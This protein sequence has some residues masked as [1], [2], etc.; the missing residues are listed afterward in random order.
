MFLM[1]GTP[2]PNS[3][4]LKTGTKYRF[5][6]INITGATAA[7]RVSLR[8]GGVPGQWRVVAKDAVDLPPAAAK[9]KLA[10][11]IVS[12]GE[13]YDVE[14]EAAGPQELTLEGLNPNDGRRATQTLVFTDPSE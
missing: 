2:Q 3:M 12:V 9:M 13:T 5:R 14:Y 10:D 8:Q 7:L 1:N 4:K 6:L 11:Q